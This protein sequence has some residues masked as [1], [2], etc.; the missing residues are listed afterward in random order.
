MK[1]KIASKE[2]ETITTKIFSN[3][4]ELDYAEDSDITYSKHPTRILVPE[5]FIRKG[6]SK[7]D[8]LQL[9][10]SF[11]KSLNKKNR[12]LKNKYPSSEIVRF[13]Q[14]GKGTLVTNSQLKLISLAEEGADVNILYEKHRGQ[15]PEEYKKQIISF[16]KTAKKKKAVVLEIESRSIELKIAEAINIGIKDFYIISGMYEK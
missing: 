8:L 6:K 9:P 12:Q 14:F 4:S 7:E 13:L 15:K 1:Q 2:I 3:H 5:R 10:D 11:I 16:C